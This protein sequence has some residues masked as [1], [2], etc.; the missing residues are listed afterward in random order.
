MAG[1]EAVTLTILEMPTHVHSMGP[2]VEVSA[3]A[4]NATSEIALSTPSVAPG[5]AMSSPVGN[6]L[7]HDNMPPFAVITFCIVSN[8]VYPELS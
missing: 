2:T 7:P 8:G 5:A 6:S 1:E 3:T 4:G